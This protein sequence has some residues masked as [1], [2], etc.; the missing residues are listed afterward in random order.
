LQELVAMRPLLRPVGQGGF[1]QRLGKRDSGLTMLQELV[2][3][4]RRR[5]MLAGISLRPEDQIS[6]VQVC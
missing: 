3:V 1:Q 4:L 5:R 2:R 6:P